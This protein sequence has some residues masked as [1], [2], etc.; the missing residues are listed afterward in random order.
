MIEKFNIDFVISHFQ[1]TNLKYY[2]DL[3]REASKPDL[4]QLR[5]EVKRHKKHNRQNQAFSKVR[6]FS[7][8]DAIISAINHELLKRSFYYFFYKMLLRIRSPI[9]KTFTGLNL[10]E[11]EYFGT[12]YCEPKRRH[13]YFLQM[14]HY[15]LFPIL[16]N[17]LVTNWKFI[18]G[19]IL[20][21]IG[22]YIA[23]ARR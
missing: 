19:S 7:T 1:A 23:W 9:V 22:L 3:L 6:N 8:H 21:I 11:H 14:P 4:R 15:E 17:F 13:H 16:G 18:I 20:T 10:K 5:L 12:L 2:L